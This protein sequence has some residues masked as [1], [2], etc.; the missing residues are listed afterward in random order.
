MLEQYN[1]NSNLESIKIVGFKELTQTDELY[2]THA[3]QT[4]C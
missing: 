3:R 1:N 2:Y 4:P